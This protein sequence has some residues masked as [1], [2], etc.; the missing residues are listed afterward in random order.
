[1]DEIS[2]V[3]LSLHLTLGICFTPSSRAASALP[4]TVRQDRCA[5]GASVSR[6]NRQILL[7][8]D[9]FVGKERLLATTSLK[10]AS[11]NIFESFMFYRLI[12]LHQLWFVV[13]KV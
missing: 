12:D 4:G 11:I 10:R 5:S 8:G 3:P 6:L 13:N 7:N 9:C 2:G 1:M